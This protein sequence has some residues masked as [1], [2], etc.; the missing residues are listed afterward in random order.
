[1]LR[2]LSPDHMRKPAPFKYR[3]LQAIITG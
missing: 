2:L 1:M 3:E